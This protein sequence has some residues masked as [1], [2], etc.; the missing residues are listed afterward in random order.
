MNRLL[1]LL[2]LL[3]FAG[4]GLAEDYAAGDLLIK[5]VWARPTPPVAGTGAAYFTLDNSK[6]QGDRLLSA[7]ADVSTR[8]EMHTHIMEGDMMK[9]RKLETAEV[10]AG[11]TVTFEPGGLHVML[12]GL[13]GPLVEGSTFPLKLNFEQAGTVAVEV[14][15]NQGPN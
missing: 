4:S 13:K 5:Q 7:E 14:A 15:V 3:L 8:V 10:P 1:I 9:M 12:I 2:S 11:Q 6:G